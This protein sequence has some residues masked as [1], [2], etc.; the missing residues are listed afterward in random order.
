MILYEYECAECGFTKEVYQKISDSSLTTFYCDKC[1]RVR[2]CHKVITK[3]TF[4]L[5]NGGWSKDGYSDPS[6]KLLAS[7]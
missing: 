5:L 1:C 6:K 7:I 3:T 2:D 4:K